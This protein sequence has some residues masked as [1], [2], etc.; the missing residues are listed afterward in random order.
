LPHGTHDTSVLVTVQELASRV[1]RHTL[2]TSCAALALALAAPAAAQPVPTQHAEPQ[3][4]APGVVSS[5]FA[6]TTAAF[7]PDGQT[8]YFTRSDS[9]EADNTIMMSRRVD[10]RWTAPIVAPFAGQWRDS[11]PDVS[12][13][14]NR[15]YF[16]SNRPAERGGKPLVTQLD[17]ETF[18]GANIWYVERRGA[19]WG[20]PVRLAGPINDV[21]MVYNP[22]VT[23]D[24]TLYFSG[25]LAAEPHKNEIYRSALKNGAYQAPELVAFSDT[26]WHNMDPTV[27]PD[28]R[29]VVFASNRPG[30]IGRADLFI[31]FRRDDGSWTEPESLGPSVNS[32][33]L[34]N[35]PVLAPDGKTL[36]FASD[37]ATPV[38]YPKPRE[39][40]ARLTAR[41]RQPDNGLRN[42]WYVDLS[43]WLVGRLR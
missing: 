12:P 31:V 35:A 25:A 28:E 26:R 38:V 18:P 21:P 1:R 4:F 24:G 23:R 32:A 39:D 16:V 2:V 43:P 5:E 6:E 13:D 34:E 22:S 36:Y 33:A 27:D 11:E 3:M 30:A 29:F 14:G 41:F 15:L 8:V 37:R 9:Q 42:I 17:G 7:M 40:A 19:G 20:E 10:G